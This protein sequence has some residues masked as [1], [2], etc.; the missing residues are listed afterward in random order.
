MILLFPMMD[1]DHCSENHSD[2]DFPNYNFQFFTV[3]YTNTDQFNRCDELLI[4]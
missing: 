4:C 2:S 1:N 3:L